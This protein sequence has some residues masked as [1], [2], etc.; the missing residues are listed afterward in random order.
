MGRIVSHDP[1]WF[2]ERLV[3]QAFLRNMERKNTSVPSNAGAELH[4]LISETRLSKEDVKSTLSRLS[5]KNYVYGAFPTDSLTPL[6]YEY[7]KS[8]R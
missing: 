2:N 1:D 5:Q 6:G 4:E 3:L 7:A 8:L